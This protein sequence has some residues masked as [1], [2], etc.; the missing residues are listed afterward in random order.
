LPVL[1]GLQLAAGAGQAGTDGADRDAEGLRG[2]GVVQAGPD[3]QGD[4]VLLG[5]AQ[6]LYRRV[7][8]FELPGVVEAS[9]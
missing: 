5:A 7:D 8:L 2:L 3:A 4:H 6:V 1:P 9:G